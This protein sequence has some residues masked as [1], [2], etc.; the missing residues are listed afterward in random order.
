M[1]RAELAQTNAELVA[2]RADLASSD[3]LLTDRTAQLVAARAA[4][5]AMADVGA[6]PGPR[7]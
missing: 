5:R 3:V 1:L 6:D 7:R 4:L 2:V